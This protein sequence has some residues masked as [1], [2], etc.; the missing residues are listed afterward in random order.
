MN[1]DTAPR[2][3]LET[4]GRA[5]QLEISTN[6]ASPESARTQKSILTYVVCCAFVTIV[7]LG[8]KLFLE[9]FSFEKQAE[10]ETR[11][12]ML[13]LLPS[14]RESGPDALVL[15]VSHLPGGTREPAKLRRVV[16]PRDDLRALLDA[17]VELSPAAIGIDIDFSGD[18]HGWLD[19]D[20]PSFFDHCLELN[21]RVPI[22]L[23][24]ARSIPSSN[25]D[26]LVS[27]LYSELAAAIYVTDSDSG[28][29]P[30]SVGIKGSHIRI[31]TLGASLAAAAMSSAWDPLALKAGELGTQ[32]WLFEKTI[33]RSSRQPP[34][35]LV[36]DS[37]E[38]P[39]NF[40]VVRQLTR[41]YIPKVRPDDLGRY[42]SRITGRIII[43]G[44]VENA[45]DVY[46]IPGDRT[47]RSGVFLHAAQAHSFTSEPIYVFSHNFRILID[48]ALP[49]LVMSC[50][51]AARYLMRD[52][53]PAARDAVESRI[54]AIAALAVVLL[55]ISL[56]YYLRVFWL[57]F[58]VV[59]IFLYV[60]RPLEHWALSKA[61]ARRREY[62]V[63]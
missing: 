57:D 22:R 41:E 56:A 6:V 61:H 58:L 31:L 19:A 28:E 48:V 30:I 13:R 23:G 5:D 32:S 59:L 54:V 2:A 8:I 46:P 38:A 18:S 42:A 29:M 39:V 25:G 7:L 45:H 51:L 44:D 27:P 63:R 34:Y 17:L 9:R 11:A 62:L 26:W 24:V 4:G 52:G 55:A 43:V 49:L 60:H 20:D 35:S 37:V 1:R 14:F 15:D 36:L 21:R 10:Y 33:E 40:S 53:N 3:G 12:Y 47:N 16:T 50:I